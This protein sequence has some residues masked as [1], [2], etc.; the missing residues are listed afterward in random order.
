MRTR[1]ARLPDAPRIQELIAIYSKRELL[2]PRSLDEICQNIH[3]FTVAV[4]RGRVV[5]CGGLHFYG[6]DMAEVR[7][8]AVAPETQGKGAGQRI[9]RAL[10][11]E[12]ARHG[13]ARICLFTHIPEWFARMGFVAVPHHTLPEKMFKDCLKC[14]R[15][16]CCDEVAMV[17]GGTGALAQPERET[18]P[19]HC[20]TPYVQ[21][22]SLRG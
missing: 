8:I 15:I 19:Q 6:P 5:G 18:R 11:K 3:N 12:A 16:Q 13:I 10:L 21:L 17:Y 22:R 7:S 2:L 1:K 20:A 14:P 4:E 9:V